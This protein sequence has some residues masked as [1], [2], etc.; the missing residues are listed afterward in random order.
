MTEEWLTIIWSRLL[1]F[2]KKKIVNFK[3]TASDFI[4]KY[5]PDI[6]LI[7]RVFFHLVENKNA[8]EPFAFLATYSVSSTTVGKPAHLPLKN[9][10]IEYGKNNKKL[11]ELLS[12]V[13][14]A[15]RQSRFI[16][17]ILESGEIFHPLSLSANDALVILKEITIYEQ[18]GILCRVPKWCKK[19]SSKI[20][21]NVQIGSAEPALLNM[22]SLLSFNARILLGGEQISLDETE[23]ILTENEGLALIKKNGLK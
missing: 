16:A 7:G 6:H 10:L 9:A 12:T 3:G 18:C 15:S 11:L 22:Q 17:E 21:V 13:Y 19:K 4:S 14:A 23:K 8:D 5:Y 1:S 2:Y 20:S